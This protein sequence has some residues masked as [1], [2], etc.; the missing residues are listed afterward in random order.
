MKQK[1]LFKILTILFFGIIINT[2]AQTQGDIAF[3]GFNADGDDDFAIVVLN[4]VPANTKIWF[5][6][7]EPTGANTIESGEGKVEWDSG[8][9]EITVGT[10]VIFSDFD[11][12]ASREASVGSF[13]DKSG[14]FNLAVGGDALFA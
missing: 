8:D 3:V 14:T 6:D 5:T 11:S 1:Y 9:S 7:S 10:I 4:D 13:T 12:S 2:N